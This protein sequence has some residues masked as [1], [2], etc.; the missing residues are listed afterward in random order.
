[1]NLMSISS[2]D[3]WSILLILLAVPIGFL[4]AWQARDEL[5][6]GRSWFRALFIASIL[7]GIWAFLSKE[8]GIGFTC[9]FILIV[10]LISYIKSFDIS[11]TRRHAS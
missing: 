11:W 5:L 6:L 4:I 9:A 3:L 8:P 2:S 1:M 10:S 7:V